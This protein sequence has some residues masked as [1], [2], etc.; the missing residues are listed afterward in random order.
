MNY[1][2]AVGY[3]TILHS[4]GGLTKEQKS[5]WLSTLSNQNSKKKT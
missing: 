5:Q 3:A 4:L 2:K 1:K